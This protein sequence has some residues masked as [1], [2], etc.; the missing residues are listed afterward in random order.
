MECFDGQW[1]ET[2]YKQNDL[3]SSFIG[4]FDG[5]WVEIVYKQNQ[6]HSKRQEVTTKIK[7]TD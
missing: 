7:F 1:V 5:Q 4:C 3:Q 6:L 2:V